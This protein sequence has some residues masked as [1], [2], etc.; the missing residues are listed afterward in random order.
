MSRG[1]GDVY[2]RQYIRYASILVD[3]YS[4]PDDNGRYF[5]FSAAPLQRIYKNIDGYW[6]IPR[7][8]KE[9]YYRLSLLKGIATYKNI[10]TVVIDK[11]VSNYRETVIKFRNESQNELLSEDFWP[12]A[13]GEDIHYLISTL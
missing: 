5:D 12:D 2:K 7:S 11:L 3:P 4:T 13:Y 8:P 1:L 9:D 10:P 6:Y